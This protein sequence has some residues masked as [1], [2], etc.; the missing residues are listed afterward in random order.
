M[1]NLN[2]LKG[3]GN[4]HEDAYDFVEMH[5][6]DQKSYEDPLDE[7][8]LMLGL[9]NPIDGLKLYLEAVN[10]VRKDS[11]RE[12]LKRERIVP[13][14][15][16]EKGDDNME[17]R[18]FKVGD[19]VKVNDRESFKP[20]TGIGEIIHIDDEAM[21][22]P[23]LVGIK[24]FDGHSGNALGAENIAKQ[25]G[26]DMQCWWCGESWLELL[27]E[28]EMTPFEVLL[29][30]WGIKV[31]EKFNIDGGVFNPYHFDEDGYLYDSDGEKSGVGILAEMLA[32][33]MKIEKIKVKEMTIADIE[34]ELGYAIKVVKEEK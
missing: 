4:Y 7:E 21:P 33:E 16:T 34:K 5:F 3:W 9:I 30:H 22:V 24:G 8:T 25:K 32:G 23:Y 12:R 13:R 17:Q 10:D 31:G 1:A 6:A 14:E 18:K 28:E 29:N 11:L 20:C 2:I 26:Y 15:T 27:E 19:K